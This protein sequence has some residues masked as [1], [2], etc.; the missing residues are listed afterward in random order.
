MRPC[1][2][3]DLKSVKYGDHLYYI[4]GKIKTVRVNGAPKTWKTRPNEISVPYKYELY[5]YGYI[6]ESDLGTMFIEDGG[7]K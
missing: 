7:A 6:T 2:L 3:E 5:T 4:D 1:T